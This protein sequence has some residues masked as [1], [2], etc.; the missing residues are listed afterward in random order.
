MRLEKAHRQGIVHRDLKPANIM[1]TKSGAKLLDFG[2]AKS[3]FK[4]TALNASH[5]E[6]AEKPLTEEGTILGTV[7]YMAPE[8]LEG[9][10]SDGR[11]D[12]FALGQVLY[13][14]ITGQRTF[15]GTSRAAIISAIL[16][17]EPQPIAHVQPLTPPALE[18][19]IRKSLA[20]DPEERWQ[21]A[22]D[23]AS[24]L[25]WIAESSQSSPQ[26]VA[27]KVGSRKNRERIAWALATLILMSA[28]A[29]FFFTREPRDVSLM[30]LSIVPEGET[31]IT[32][33][34]ALSPDGRSVAFVA[35]TLSGETSLWV[36]ST[37]WS[38]ARKLPGTSNAVYPFLVSR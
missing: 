14:M 21:S 32:G 25:K 10:E 17:S 16:S 36:R 12:I 31:R 35:K 8:Q 13:E 18:H 27:E 20:K 11:T 28:A 5:L 24:E 15:K 2:L 37:S 29:F 23:I 6:T 7:Q 38:N 26:A 22:H 4:E 30:R 33:Q 19:L 1:L 3:S 34:L 9:R